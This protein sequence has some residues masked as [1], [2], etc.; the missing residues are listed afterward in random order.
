LQGT[1]GSMLHPY[2]A[3]GLTND[4]LQWRLVFG[5]LL[6]ATTYS[7][8]QV[9]GMLLDNSSRLLFMPRVFVFNTIDTSCTYRGNFSTIEG[10]CDCSQGYGG[11]RCQYCDVGYTD[12]DQTGSNPICVMYECKPD[13]CGCDPAFSESCVPLGK[14][15]MGTSGF[16]VC[17]CGVAYGGQYC[18]SCASGYHSYPNCVAYQF[19]NPAC[20]HG[21]CDS[22][23]GKCNCPS[24]FVGARCDQCAP[25]F[26]GSSCSDYN[27]GGQNWSTTLAFFEITGIIVFVGGIA[28]F[29]FWYIKRRRGSIRYNTLPRFDEDDEGLLPQY[30]NRLHQEEDPAQV[31]GINIDPNDIGSPPPVPTPSSGQSG[32][33]APSKPRLLDM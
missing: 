15:T 12:I 1:D 22:N 5:G 26:S 25:D 14:C 18:D 27:A 13:S 16:V 4:G 31:F 2:L 20:I 29:A 8:Q 7:L 30:D 17:D 24:N 3:Q 10:R 6:P 21:T 32:Q 28:A 11:I 9:S 19:C 23:L 33:V